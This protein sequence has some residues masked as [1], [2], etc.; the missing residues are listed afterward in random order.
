MAR[1]LLLCFGFS[2][3]TAQFCVA[4]KKWKDQYY[5]ELTDENF[6]DFKGFKKQIN[7][8]D[9]DYKTLNAAVYF[10]SNEARIE[11]GLPALSY[12]ENLEI[13]AWNHSVKMGKDDFF[14]HVHPKSKKRKKPFNRAKLAGIKNPQISENITAIG[15]VSYGTYLELADALVDSWIDSPLYRATLYSNDALELGCGVYYYTGIWQKNKDIHK[16]GNGFW[17]ATQNFQLFTKVDARASK[18][19]R[20]N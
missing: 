9:P 4:Q 7:L 18:D 14:D 3:V 15:G 5:L 12:Q 1:M 20:P 10:V 2:L 6:R 19:K 11:Q 16:E 13:M 8:K 17:L